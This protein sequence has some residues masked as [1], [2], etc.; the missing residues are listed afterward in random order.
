METTEPL[1]ARELIPG[2]RYIIINDYG[3][4]NG[5]FQ[6]YDYFNYTFSFSFIHV[7][8]EKIIDEESELPYFR[9]PTSKFYNFI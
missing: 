3:V 2:N 4:H 9:F 1:T 5:I 8:R 6:R 7:N